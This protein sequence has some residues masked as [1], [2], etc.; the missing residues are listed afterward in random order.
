MKDMFIFIFG[1]ILIFKALKKM[2]NDYLMKISRK[3]YDVATCSDRQ[4][5]FSSEWPCL[6]IVKQ[7]TFSV[8]GATTIYTHNLGYYP[9][10]MIFINRADG[11]GTDAN[12]RL[13]YIPYSSAFEMSTTA[14]ECTIPVT[15][16]GYYYIFALDLETNYT[17]PII[18]PSDVSQGETNDYVYAISKNG[19]DISSTDYRD[20]V[21][22]SDCRSPMVH[23]VHNWTEPGLGGS[24]TITHNLG[25]E[26]MFF[27]FVRNLQG[28][29]SGYIMY[30]NADDATIT[31]TT[32]DLDAASVYDGTYSMVIFK[33]PIL[34]Q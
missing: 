29:G 34:V 22:H 5:V 7:G 24:E 21:V 14:L 8:T 6:K 30:G 17:A 27:G 11:G 33:D 23:I 20:F 2:A 26:P 15:V 28:T 32:T 3:G 31:A 12:S 16:D 18:Q 10:F 1:V 13:S 9:F 4:L 25:Y 19:E